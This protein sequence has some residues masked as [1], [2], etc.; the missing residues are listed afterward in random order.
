MALTDATSASC[1]IGGR[2][3]S[4]RQRPRVAP[5]ADHNVDGP[6]QL[7]GMTSA[8]RNVKRRYVSEWCEASEP[9]RQRTATTAWR[10][11]S[12]PQRRAPLRQRAARRQR[13]ATSEGRDVSEPQR[14]ARNVK[15]ATWARRYVKA[16]KRQR[17]AK[18][19]Y[20][21]V[22]ETTVPGTDSSKY[23]Y[24][25]LGIKGPLFWADPR[26]FGVLPRPV[27]WHYV[28]ITP[29][30]NNVCTFGTFGTFGTLTRHL[31][32]TL[33]KASCLS[34]AQVPSPRIWLSSAY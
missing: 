17:G 20:A 26:N 25:Y 11:V 27:Y 28:E 12:E 15:R 10:D 7:R 2:D 32:V 16:P 31:A 23:K 9:Q 1:D 22:G 24:I 21:V 30:A 6:R 14:Q 33:A 34:A 5:S 19:V 13:S 3:D 4:G 18:L 8:S 29:N